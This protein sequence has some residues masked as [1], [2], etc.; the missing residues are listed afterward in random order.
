VA[1]IEY[2]RAFSESRITK[3]LYMGFES[4]VNEGLNLIDYIGGVDE[5]A[6]LY[7]LYFNPSKEVL[8]KTIGYTFAGVYGSAVFF[9]APTDTKKAR[10]YYEKLRIYAPDIYSTKTAEDFLI[11]C[12]TEQLSK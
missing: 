9:Y 11:H 3:E 6:R 12:E 4:W 5:A 2:I 7:K 10:D 1:A 8:K